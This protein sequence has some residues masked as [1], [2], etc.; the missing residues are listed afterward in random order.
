VASGIRQAGALSGGGSSGLFA[1]PVAEQ[2][3]IAAQ[4]PLLERALAWARGEPLPSS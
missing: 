4:R 3:I 1:A 2:K